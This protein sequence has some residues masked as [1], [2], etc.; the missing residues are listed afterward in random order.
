MIMKVVVFGFILVIVGFGL[1]GFGSVPKGFYL[2]LEAKNPVFEQKLAMQAQ[3]Q[4]I[5]MLITPVSR[6]TG[7]P[8][9]IR[10]EGKVTLQPYQS[11]MDTPFGKM[12]LKSGYQSA[13]AEANLLFYVAGKDEPEHQ[14]FHVFGSQEWSTSHELY[15]ALSSDIVSQLK[16]Y[17]KP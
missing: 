10:I 11:G 8:Q 5:E 2:V 6:R 4:G 3:G 16:E 13:W 15:Q 1:S 12:G 17:L 14:I 7:V 9:Q